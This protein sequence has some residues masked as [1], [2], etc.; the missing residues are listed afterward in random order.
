[1]ES[2]EGFTWYGEKGEPL[3]FEDLT[4]TEQR[5]VLI[6]AGGLLRGAA[7]KREEAGFEPKELSTA[8]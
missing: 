5:T 1:M 8:G 4:P 7:K 3:K 6:A 2:L